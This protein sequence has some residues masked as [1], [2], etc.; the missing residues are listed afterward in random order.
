VIDSGVTDFSAEVEIKVDDYGDQMFG[1][2]ARY[3]GEKDWIMAFHDGVG[4][5]VL[6]KMVADEDL[7]GRGP[8]DLLYEGPGGFQEMGRIP[9]DM[10][11]RKKAHKIKVV[12]SGD[13]IQVYANGNL[14]LTRTDDD[15]SAST[16]VGV[17]SRGVG[18]NRF[19]KFTVSQD[20]GGGGKGGGKPSKKSA[21]SPQPSTAPG[22][23]ED[24]DDDKGKGK[25]GKN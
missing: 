24:D 25:K 4:E 17:F 16:K 10:T 1:V 9:V 23:D 18:I 13:T 21:S 14:I 5:I 11:E 7:R 2:V 15:H 12:T 19:D 22:D 20:G 6:G 8:L 3:S